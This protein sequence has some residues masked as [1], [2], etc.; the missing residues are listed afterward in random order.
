MLTVMQY[1]NEMIDTIEGSK[2]LPGFNRK[3]VDE[4]QLLE[5]L[6]RVKANLPEE[7]MQAEQILETRD[8]I[9]VEAKSE[10]DRIVKERENYLARM[11]A[12]DEI[13]KRAQQIAEEIIDES[14]RRADETVEGA[15]YYADNILGKLEESLTHTLQTIRKGRLKIESMKSGGQQ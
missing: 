5:L 12:D 4:E 3:L 15:N 2:K 1:I 14:K 9:I 7:M 8:Q 6:D 13:T 10:A 11:S